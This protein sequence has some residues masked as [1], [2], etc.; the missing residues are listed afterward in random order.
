MRPRS[1]SHRSNEWSTTNLPI[2]SNKL[3]HHQANPFFSTTAANLASYD[4]LIIPQA[5]LR[6]LCMTL[7]SGSSNLTDFD[8]TS[9]DA[10]RLKL[11]AEAMSS[12]ESKARTESS[13]EETLPGS[14]AGAWKWAIRKQM[15]D[16]M[17]AN[18]IARFP[19]PVHHRIPNFV[20]ADL[21]ADRLAQMPE[22]ISAKTIKVN[23]DTPQKRVRM[24][25]LKSGKS[26][27]SPQPRLRTGFFSSLTLDSFPRDALMEACTSAGVVKY[28]VPLSLDAKI[29]VDLIVVGSS[30]VDKNG[31]RLGKG[32]GFAELEYG[33]LRW[34]G[35]VDE[36][37]LVVT[38]VHDCQVLE[39]P[40][41]SAKM[42]EHDVPVDVIVTPTRVI[43]TTPKISKP[44]GI[45]WHKLSPDKLSQIRVL[46]ELKRRI[47][48]ETG[49][50]L[51]TGPSEKLPPLAER[52]P[53]TNNSGAP[54]GSSGRGKTRFHHN[55]SSSSRQQRPPAST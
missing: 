40:I 31:A 49:E 22:F 37:T 11:D 5:G 24:H 21:A 10:Q 9:Y 16:Y 52:R 42:L 41:D 2:R 4:P 13:L 45:L 55:S 46:Q 3:I 39:D 15:W 18:D 28:G 33:M 1:A 26:L 53:R 32:E 14:T 17:E 34:M 29:K 43:W 30:A 12:M 47:E 48:E 51:P 25:V 54:S 7:R 44:A 19:R 23:P 27:L 38:T 6:R 8:T 35:A 36:S 20:N 50:K